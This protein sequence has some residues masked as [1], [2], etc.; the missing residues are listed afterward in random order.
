MLR[1]VGHREV[2]DALS[3]SGQAVDVLPAHEYRASHIRGA[4]HLPLASLMT[5]AESILD[6][7]RPV[8]VYCRD[9]L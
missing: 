8:I 2:L 6:K 5:K 4:V 7:S 9:S 3:A 1:V